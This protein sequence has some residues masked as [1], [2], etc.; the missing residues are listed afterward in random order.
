MPLSQRLTSLRE[1]KRTPIPKSSPSKKDESDY[2]NLKAEIDL[3]MRQKSKLLDD[4]KTLSGANDSV[5]MVRKNL[6][7]EIKTLS[8]SRMKLV[9]MV[10]SFLNKVSSLSDRASDIEEGYKRAGSAIFSEIVEA[11]RAILAESS[12]S[13]EKLLVRSQE[14]DS[15]SGQISRKSEELAESY[16]ANEEA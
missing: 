12:A 15:K 14:L 9:V 1:E 13:Y 16:E 10:K 5:D 4:L 11:A 6:L 8:E 2:Y 3:A 7:D